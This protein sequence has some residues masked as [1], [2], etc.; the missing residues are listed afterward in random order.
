MGAPRQ[1]EEA[2]PFDDTGGC[3]IRS[4]L[5]SCRRAQ[6]TTR[7]FGAEPVE[8]RGIHHNPAETPWPR[9]CLGALA[10]CPPGRAH[11][12]NALTPRGLPPGARTR[13]GLPR[14]PRSRMLD[15]WC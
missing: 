15:P 2:P 5:D 10:V 11:R 12:T 6:L 1:P 8:E 7:A 4:V 13:P 14:H 3:G 9:W